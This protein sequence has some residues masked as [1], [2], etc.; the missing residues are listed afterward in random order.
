MVKFEEN[1]TMIKTNFNEQYLPKRFKKNSKG[2]LSGTGETKNMVAHMGVEPTTSA[3][4]ARRSNQ[5]S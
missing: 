3:L 5:L 1:F 4:S 2:N